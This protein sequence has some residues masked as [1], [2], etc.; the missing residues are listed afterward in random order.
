[1]PLITTGVHS[2]PFTEKMKVDELVKIFVHKDFSSTVSITFDLLG[3]DL[4][5]STNII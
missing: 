4:K 1:M 2:C 3:N 5:S